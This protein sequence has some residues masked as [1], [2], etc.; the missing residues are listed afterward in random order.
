MPLCLFLSCIQWIL[1]AQNTDLSINIVPNSPTYANF[2]SIGY[3]V[4][5]KNLGTVNAA[6]VTVAFPKPANVSFNCAN[7]TFGAWFAWEAAGTWNIGTI[8]A[9]DS[10]RLKT[11]LFALTGNS[12]VAS[13]SVT[14]TAAGFTDPL[15]S[16][17]SFTSTITVG[18]AAPAA[19]CTLGG[20][21]LP[22]DKIDLE[23][24]T[25]INNPEVAF[26]QTAPM[27]IKIKNNSLLTATGIQVRET[28]P[29]GLSLLSFD[30]GGG[31]YT[32]A[33]GLWD[34]G[35]LAPGNE[36]ILLLDGKVIQGG[37]IKN[38]AQVIAAN[39]LDI[40][41]APNNYNPAATT[42]EDDETILNL[43]GMLVD[44]ELSMA[45]ES[46]PTPIKV[47]D[48]VTYVVTL[49]NVGPAR[50]DGTKVRTNI[51]AGMQYISSVADIGEFDP[52]VGVWLLSHIADPVTGNKPG[53][54]LAAGGTVSIRLKTKALQ[55][56]TVDFTC[57]MRSCNYPDFD[58]TPSN[59]IATEDDQATII[60]NVLQNT[61]NNFA[62]LEM[63][64]NVTHTP[65][66]TGDSI[67]YMIGVFN[68]G[69]NATTGVTV[70]CSLPTNLN[71]LTVLP[72]VGS[73]N[74][75]TGI[76]TI[77]NIANQGSVTLTIQGSA[78]CWTTANKSFAQVQTSSQPDVD[79]NVGNNSTNNP[80]E[81]DETAQTFNAINC[82]V[83]YADLELSMT[84]TPATIA[85]NTV[86]TF[87]LSVLN[88]GLLAATGVSLKDLLP[89]SLTFNSATPSVGAYNS[90]TGIWTIGNLSV[91]A[92]ATLSITATVNALTNSIVN[93]AQIQTSSILDP[94]STPG[95]DTNQSADEDD[96]A[97]VTLF[98][99]TANQ[100]DLE[101]SLT[102]PYTT[103]LPI[104]QNVPLRAVLVNRGPAAATG[105]TVK[106][107]F[108]T[109]MAFNSQVVSKGTYAS[110][111][112]IWDVGT[113]AP[114]DSAVLTITVFTLQTTI[115]HFIQV[116]TA[117]P[118]DLD[119]TPGNDTNNSPNED[120]EALLSVPSASVNP[121]IDLALNLTAD[122]SSVLPGGTVDFTIAVDNS[123]AMT[124][125]NVSVKH[126]IPNFLSYQTITPQKGT[127]DTLTRIW[128]IGTLL[129]NETATLTIVYN[130]GAI[131]G[132][133]VGFAQVQTVTQTNDPDST[134]SNNTTGT[135]TED[136]EDNVT[137][138]KQGVG[139]TCDLELTMPTTL[140]YTQY[141]AKYF[142]LTLRNVGG[143][144]ATNV[145]VDFPYPT[146]FV[147]GG[148]PTSSAGT[149]YNT[150]THIWEVGTLNPGQTVTM[151]MPLFCLDNTG[152]VTA[153][154][155]V[156]TASPIDVDSAPNNNTT[157]VPSED[158]E[159][160]IVMTQGSGNQPRFTLA[161][162]QR[163]PIVV[164]NI[165]PNPG[166]G[167]V[168]VILNA[169]YSGDVIFEWHNPLTGSVFTTKAQVSLG[170]NDLF[171]DLTSFANGVYYLQTT[172]DS[173]RLTPIKYVKF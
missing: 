109:G 124:A 81:D 17:N 80:V 36:R 23:L 92:T 8:N 68:R 125:T 24:T 32:P 131:T 51:P 29:A 121:F 37:A 111:N 28:F 135:P 59:F 151:T 127:F 165:F 96:E 73:Y 60:I 157:Q 64:H 41:S 27:L 145:T 147:N 141:V 88:R 173:G 46:T 161:Q 19:D 164:K 110:F 123:G 30:A 13:A 172:L 82:N 117:S 116:K 55:V 120:D 44:M 87:N 85:V 112:G 144:A 16:N 12:I 102:C 126:L 166:G 83:N 26:N 119:S 106:Y 34:V 130:V 91:N 14:S 4:T 75:I 168:N 20:G 33:T 50:G 35:S 138:F 107:P 103:A 160:A 98:S 167:E 94:D 153:F 58:S 62:D 139:T 71:N 169:T 1:V 162:P 142:N 49:R 66:V 54:M 15:P 108:P 152:A 11:V 154:A 143:V 21:I 79:S 18:T 48:T 146:K 84:A 38:V 39:Q 67:R 132:N 136:D 148:N 9:G 90:T 149:T 52:S 97:K 104:Y 31:T 100:C 133:I 170:E 10:A 105:I 5:V 156:K 114:G 72:S 129:S 25:S 2:T 47:G 6:N 57:E 70:K 77:G 74:V 122:K 159:A 101:L 53:F 95:N 86:V 43:T 63:S 137:V 78:G 56:G 93:F 140:T 22:T 61:S 65:L 155:Q 99:A 113:L 128:T 158:D 115:S 150:F 118:T 45:L 3:T 163:T 89:T 76:W 7:A 134:P 171:F 40:D 69:Q 42:H